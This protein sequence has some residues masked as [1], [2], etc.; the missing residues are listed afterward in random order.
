MG[1]NGGGA[2]FLVAEIRVACALFVIFLSFM[3]FERDKDE[4][5]RPHPFPFVHFTDFSFAQPIPSLVTS[6]SESGQD[7]EQD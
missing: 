6:G 1:I 3:L 5:T 7:Q 4:H 2:L